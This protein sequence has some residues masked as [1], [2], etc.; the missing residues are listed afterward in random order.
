MPLS[1]GGPPDGRPASPL[2]LIA[3]TGHKTIESLDVPGVHR[4]EVLAYGVGEVGIGQHEFYHVAVV[5]GAAGGQLEFDE[6]R[7]KD[8]GE[9]PAL[10]PQPRG[11]GDRGGGGLGL[12]GLYLCRRRPSAQPRRRGGWNDNQ[13]SRLGWHSVDP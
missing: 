8:V 7:Q 4:G 13:H 10:G 9:T 3:C 11:M 1:Q 2:G 12:R 5:A 6:A